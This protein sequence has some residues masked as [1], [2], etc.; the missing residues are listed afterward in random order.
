VDVL[1]VLNLGGW[2]SI[3]FY[4]VYRNMWNKDNRI[5]LRIVILAYLLFLILISIWAI[6]YSLFIE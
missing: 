3:L 2:V 5:G 4:F 6:W 1:Q